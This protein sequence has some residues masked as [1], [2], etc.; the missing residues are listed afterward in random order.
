[1]DKANTIKLLPPQIKGGK[2][3]MEALNERKTLREFSPQE[4]SLQ[5]LSDMLWAANGINRAQAN[6]HTAP[7]AMNMQEIEIYLALA[8]GLY[9]YDAK[10]NILKQILCNDIREI[11]GKQPFVKG[12]PVNLVFVAELK[13]MGEVSPVDTNFYAGIDTG[14]ISQNIYLFCASQGLATVARGYLD[15]SVLGAAMKLNDQQRVILTQTVGYPK[16]D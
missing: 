13:K 14:F 3:L 15:K 5:I 12:A 9:L 4:L 11:T 6:G 2:P 10:G 1:M 8:G 16:K 7:S